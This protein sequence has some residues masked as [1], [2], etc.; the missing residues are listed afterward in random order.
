MKKN[1]IQVILPDAIVDKFEKEAIKQNRSKSNLAGR[2]IIEGLSKINN[3][4]TVNK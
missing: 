4:S 3:E 2:L 1:R